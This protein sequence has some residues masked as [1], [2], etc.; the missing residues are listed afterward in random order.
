MKVWFCG[1]LAVAMCLLL[2]GVQTAFAAANPEQC[3]PAPNAVL[4]VAPREIRCIFT[5]SL[6]VP[7]S[8]FAVFDANNQQVDNRDTK[9]DPADE[10][11][12]TLI[13]TLNAAA[14]QNGV[15]RVQWYSESEGGERLT[16]QWSFTLDLGTSVPAGTS[17]TPTS[18]PTTTT[19][20]GTTASTT[21]APQ[22]SPQNT[23]SVGSA[24]AEV[25]APPVVVPP[26]PNAADLPPGKGG[27]VVRNYHGQQLTFTLNGEQHAIPAN[28]WMLVTLGPAGYSYSANVFGDDDTEAMGTVEVKAGELSERAFWL[29]ARRQPPPEEEEKEDGD[30]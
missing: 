18:A 24:S 16:G 5:E 2:P 29:I 11:D 8:G 10:D 13:T 23:G 26:G 27:L 15:Y 30:E 22:G 4:K 28:D 25:P 17:T 14:M 6:V 21:S 7:P 9:L 3:N 12:V 1:A 20:T 19:T